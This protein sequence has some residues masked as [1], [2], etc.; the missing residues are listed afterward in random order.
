MYVMVVV[1][2]GNVKIGILGGIGPEAT[3][4]FYLD[5]FGRLQRLGISSNRDFP[6]VVVNSIP[7]P[8]LVGE[9]I[10]DA[11]LSSY[12]T[13]LRQ[14]DDSG[15]DFIAMVCNTIHLYHDELQRGIRAPI[16]D[17]KE[18]VREKLVRDGVKKVTV[19][20]THNTLAQGLY[21]F[22]E[23]ENI[24]ISPH[25]VNELEDAIVNYNK[26]KDMDSQIQTVKSIA[27]KYLAKGAEAII[28]GCTEFA[29][30]LRDVDIPKIDT[31][32]VLVDATI[33]HKELENNRRAMVQYLFENAC[34][35]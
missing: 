2:G 24:D 25:E 20:G 33:R 21:S 15:V 22:P 12:R 11:Q 31:L 10:S 9:D 8:E 4:R 19:L 13:G 23:I 29:V 28:L 6:Q 27:E 3:G 16:I 26:G 30:M 32:D 17:I 7:A 35:E 18:R 14:L 34:E 5:L 1:F